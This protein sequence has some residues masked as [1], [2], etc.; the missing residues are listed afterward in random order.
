MDAKNWSVRVVRGG[1][2]VELGRVTENSERSARHKALRLFGVADYQV[3]V[4]G[5][6]PRGVA[7]YP[8]EEFEVL[9]TSDEL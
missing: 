2:L 3:E 5:V 1:E 8:D 6:R 9:L 7:I 4:E